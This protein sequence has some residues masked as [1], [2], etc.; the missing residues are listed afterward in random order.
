MQLL[1]LGA[2]GGTGRALVEQAS[3]R[4]HRVT[5]F[6][7]SPE[8]L[9]PPLSG[10]TA[11]RGDPRNA[12]Q[13]V[14]ALRGCDAVLSALG[15]P[16]P[17]RSWPRSTTIL[18]DAARSTVLAMTSAGVRRV[19]F[20]SGDLMFPDGGPPALLRVTLLRHLAKDQAEMERVVRASEL[21]WTLVRPTRLTNGPFTGEQ[22]FEV[23]AMP[24]APRGISRADVADFLLGAAERGDHLREIVGL[25][26]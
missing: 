24:R 17:P 15:P 8:K 11:V 5:A 2:T 3:Q 14:D 6:V 10:V 9:G 19:L 23:G 18:G 4:G 20:I 25:A 12:A 26:R 16:L 1:I 13:L 22:R 7:R 21:D